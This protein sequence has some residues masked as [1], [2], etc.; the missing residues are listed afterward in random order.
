MRMLMCIFTLA[1]SGNAAHGPGS[2]WAGDP[3]SQS[4]TPL[5]F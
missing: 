3:M 4:E 2:G 5:N 1:K